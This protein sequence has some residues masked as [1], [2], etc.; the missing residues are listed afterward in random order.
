MI[1]YLN[2][3]VKTT[4]G[5]RAI[6]LHMGMLPEVILNKIMSYD[7]H[8]I[9]DMLKE[10]TIFKCLQLREIS[11][12]NGWQSPLDSYS[13]AFDLGCDSIMIIWVM[14]CYHLLFEEGLH[15]MK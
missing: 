13:C 11:I 7:S 14:I 9:A 8:P 12:E 3:R 1:L 4:Q 10:S 2:Y 15:G 6:L 5:R